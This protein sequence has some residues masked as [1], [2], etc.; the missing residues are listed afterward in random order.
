MKEDTLQDT[1]I[2]ITQPVTEQ[3]LNHNKKE[4]KKI[5]MNVANTQYSVVRKVAK[6][7]FRFKLSYAVSSDWDIF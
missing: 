4:K 1:S 6:K 2:E 3:L 7:V 5:V